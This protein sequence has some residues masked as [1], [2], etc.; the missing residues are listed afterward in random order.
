MTDD[1]DTVKRDQKKKPAKKVGR[2]KNSKTTP[3]R[4]G[5]K[6]WVPQKKDWSTHKPRKAYLKGIRS[7][8]GICEFFCVI[9][10][11]NEKLPPIRKMTDEQIVALVVKEFPDA[12]GTKMLQEGRRTLN[13][14][15]GHYNSGV[16]NGGKKPVTKSRRFNEKGVPV[17]MRTGRVL[18]DRKKTRKQKFREVQLKNPDVLKALG[19][20]DSTKGIYRPGMVEDQDVAKVAKAAEWM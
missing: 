7:G 11:A 10:E 20:T 17:S 8:L 14:Y 9:F 12:P 3:K 16:I 19:I 4:K 5:F 15:R 18:I 13:Y 2:P 6:L 1:N